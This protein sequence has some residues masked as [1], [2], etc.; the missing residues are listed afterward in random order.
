[1]S[2]PGCGTVI[3]FCR[4]RTDISWKT[5]LVSRRCSAVVIICT[6]GSNGKISENCLREP[7]RSIDSEP[8]LSVDDEAENTL[9]CWLEDLLEL[10]FTN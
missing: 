3:S 4:S 7:S 9:A 2:A 5:R 10:H 1:M 8:Y 6:R